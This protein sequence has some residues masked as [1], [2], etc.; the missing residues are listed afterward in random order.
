MS[1]DKMPADLIKNKLFVVIIIM[2][3]AFTSIL[4]LSNYT[5]ID[6]HTEPQNDAHIKQY[7]TQQYL[8]PKKRFL[9]GKFIYFIQKFHII[10]YIVNNIEIC[11]GCHHVYLDVGTNIGIQVK[12][13]FL[14]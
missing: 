7:I 5:R 6:V 3:I 2:G 9:D 8:P 10:T 13:D 14:D 11:L 12:I 1:I 4:F